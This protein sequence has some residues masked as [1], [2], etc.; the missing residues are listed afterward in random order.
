MI[1]RP[2]LRAEYA[3]DR[4][5]VIGT[6]AYFYADD[7]QHGAE[8]WQTDGTKA[9]TKLVGEVIP[10]PGG[11]YPGLV[12]V[13]GKVGTRI[14]FTADDGVHGLELWRTTSGGVALWANIKPD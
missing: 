4:C 11:V 8:P 2:A 6:R 5:V 10:G 14:Y 3:R 9:G 13:F 12:K 7:G 1:R